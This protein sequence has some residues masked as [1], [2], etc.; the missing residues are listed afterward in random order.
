[1]RES[2]WGKLASTAEM[3]YEVRR[4][5]DTLAGIWGDGSAEARR[6]YEGFEYPVV[7]HGLGITFAVS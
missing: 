1:M 6:R 4:V 3:G 7:N 5:M 2:G